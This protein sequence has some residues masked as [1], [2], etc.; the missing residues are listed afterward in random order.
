M[1]NNIDNAVD[2]NTVPKQ[3]LKRHSIISV[4]LI[5]EILLFIGPFTGA[6]FMLL[7]EQLFPNQSDE[8]K[9]VMNSYFPFVGLVILLLLFCHFWE[10]DILKT[11]FSQKNGGLQGNNKKMFLLGL[12]LGFGSNGICILVAWLN[13]DVTFIVG[14]FTVPYLLF[15]F[16]NVLIQSGAEEMLS[17]GYIQSSLQE[18]YGIAVAII[19]NGLFFGLMHLA[20][21][22]ITVLSCINILLYGVVMSMVTFYFKS[23]WFCVAHHTAWNFTQNFVFGLP[24]SGLAAEKSFFQ[25]AKSNHSIVY[26]GQFGVEGGI[27]VCLISVFSITILLTCFKK[28]ERQILE[29]IT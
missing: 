10:K 9:F 29:E 27:V 14:S 16:V 3:K 5:S 11:M 28:R 12:L 6:I 22:G 1:K 19:I 8:V 7:L 20:N 2:S 26:D 24:N 23:L 18:R 21:P 15:A 25:L 17:R 13:H 4:L